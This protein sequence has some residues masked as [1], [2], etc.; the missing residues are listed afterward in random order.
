MVKGV[1]VNIIGERNSRNNKFI[2]NYYPGDQDLPK[3]IGGA[4]VL[5]KQKNEGPWSCPGHPDHP[6]LLLPT[7]QLVDRETRNPKWRLV[8][9]YPSS[10]SM[11]IP[12]A[13][14]LIIAYPASEVNA[15]RFHEND[16]ERK[17]VLVVA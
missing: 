12:S 11:V 7:F 2:D 6:G 4:E 8:Y 1:L 10:V 16:V 15:E 13:V 3:L 5:R 9:S 14:K 17:V